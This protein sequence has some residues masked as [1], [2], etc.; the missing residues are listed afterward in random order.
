MKKKLG[1]NLKFAM[2]VTIGVVAGIEAGQ[3]ALVYCPKKKDIAIFPHQ[4][5]RIY[6]GTT[7]GAKNIFIAS[8]N[9]YHGE[10]TGPITSEVRGK[11]IYCHY[12]SSLF[13]FSDTQENCHA[14]DENNKD[15]PE[16]ELGV[17]FNCQ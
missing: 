3:A 13:L 4:N 7:T 1:K 15:L 8:M 10:V 11:Q 17:A 16:H 12:G 5:F 14:V 2:L 6:S 9:E